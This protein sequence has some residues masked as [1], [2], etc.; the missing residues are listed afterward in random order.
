MQH[1][2]VERPGD[3]LIVLANHH[4]LLLK[5]YGD[6]IVHSPP[7]ESDPRANRRGKR[8]GRPRSAESAASTVFITRTARVLLPERTQP[9]GME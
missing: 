3:L 7:V 6:L 5:F 2:V 1:R 9:A 4:W 8:T